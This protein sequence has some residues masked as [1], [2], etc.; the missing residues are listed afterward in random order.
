MEG[1]GLFRASASSDAYA[2]TGFAIWKAF[3]KVQGGEGWHSGEGYTYN[4]STSPFSYLANADG[5]VFNVANVN[6][7]IGGIHGQWIKLECPHAMRLGKIVLQARTN[8]ETQA[9]KDFSVLGSNNNSDW[10]ILQSYVGVTASTSGVQH[11]VDSNSSY[12]YFALVTTRTQSTSD[13]DLVISEI[14]FFGTPA[15]SSLEDGHLTL[16]KAL[17]APRVSGHPAGAETPRAESLVVHY[18]T[19]VDSVASGSTVVDISGQGSNG[20]FNG[21]ASYSSTDRSLNLDAT[22]DSIYIGNI[23]N[24]AGAWVHSVSFWIYFLDLT[25]DRVFEVVGVG[26][27]QDKIPHFVLESAWR[28]SMGF[29][30]LKH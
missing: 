16:G 10:D 19:T 30:R 21:N 27:T 5:A 1:H 24:Q 3:N 2:H 22:G 20:T 13:V 8:L 4:G 15:P 17:T 12:K 14:K 28:C 18:D 25:S 7:S 23:G 9:P 26:N 6:Q 29:L 11:E